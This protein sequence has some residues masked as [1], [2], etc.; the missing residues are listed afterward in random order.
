MNKANEKKPAANKVNEKK[1]AVN[2]EKEKKPAVN[3]EKEK[4]P[5][6]K[7]EKQKVNARLYNTTLD[8][9]NTLDFIILRIYCILIYNAYESERDHFLSCLDITEGKECLAVSWLTCHHSLI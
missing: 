4:K 9:N 1:P 8:A 6:A 7:E 5:V 2:E 3:E